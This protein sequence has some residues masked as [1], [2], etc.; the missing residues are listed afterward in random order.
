MVNT[1]KGLW[2][3]IKVHYDV[4]CRLELCIYLQDLL[5]LYR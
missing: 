1:N 4:E 3:Y 5:F 2:H